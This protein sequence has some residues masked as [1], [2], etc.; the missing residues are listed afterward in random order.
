MHVT[1]RKQTEIRKKID[2]QNQV[3]VYLKL[4]ENVEARRMLFIYEASPKQIKV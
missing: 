4:I 3:R 1:R 2:R